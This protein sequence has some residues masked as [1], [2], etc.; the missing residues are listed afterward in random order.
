[1][2]VQLTLALSNDFVQRAQRWA[3]RAGCDVA[4]IITRAAVLSL[5][6]LGRERTADLDALADAQVLTLTHLQMGPAQDARLSILL[7][8]QQAAL[9][10]PAERAELDKLMSYYEIGLL[11]KAEAL[12]E[13]VRRGLREPLHP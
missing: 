6:S 1:M 8:R 10:T 13:A 7:E 5:P 9:L 2:T 11:R 12:A 4:E 3:T